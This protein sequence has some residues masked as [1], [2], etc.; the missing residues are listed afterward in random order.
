MAARLLAA[1]AGKSSGGNSAYGWHQNGIET[2]P[3]EG[4]VVR[5]IVKRFIA[6]DSWNSIALD[7]SQR[8]IPASKGRLWAAINVSHVARH[9]PPQR[10]TFFR[11]G[12]IKA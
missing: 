3:Y 5:E 8:N 6:D 4:P 12:L 2:H 7:L 9:P 11:L 1:K 10:S